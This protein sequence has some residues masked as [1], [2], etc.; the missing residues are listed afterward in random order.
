[1]E[2]TY[3]MEAMATSDGYTLKQICQRH[4]LEDDFVVQCVDY[5]ITEVRGG[6]KAEDWVFS[7]N[8][9]PRL[10]KAYR[11][12]RDLGLDFTGLAVVLDLLDHIEDLNDRLDSLSNRLNEWQG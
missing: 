9:I 10:E 11:L 3:E 2:V 4:T 8:C 7:I 1:M 12:Q 6:E 5:G